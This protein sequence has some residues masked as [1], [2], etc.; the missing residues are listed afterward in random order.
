VVVILAGADSVA[1]VGDAGAI[2]RGIPVPHL[3]DFGLFSFSLVTG[4]G[5]LPYAGQ[6]GDVQVIRRTTTQPVRSI[7]GQRPRTATSI[8]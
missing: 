8:S 3:P 4:P 1:R 6:H 5:P 2:P 7:K